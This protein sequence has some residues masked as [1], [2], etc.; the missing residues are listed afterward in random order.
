MLP[1]GYA[2]LP[3]RL[4]APAPGWETT[5]DVVI[6]GSG[7]AG[8]TAAL[9]LRGRVGK[10]LVVTKDV[11]AYLKSNPVAQLATPAPGVHANH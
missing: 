7:I 1:E 11:E 9:R 5:S 8:L 6:I 2:A 3:R 10:I 4:R